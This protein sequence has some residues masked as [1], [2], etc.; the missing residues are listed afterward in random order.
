[1]LE[2]IWHFWVLVALSGLCGY[3]ALCVQSTRMLLQT[4][5]MY[6]AVQSAKMLLRMAKMYVVLMLRETAGIKLFGSGVIWRCAYNRPKC[7]QN[8]ENATGNQLVFRMRITYQ[9]RATHFSA[10][11]IMY[12]YRATR[13]SARGADHVERVT[14]YV[15][16]VFGCSYFRVVLGYVPCLTL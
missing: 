11:R 5:T 8:G 9:Y 7:Y 15:W 13:F 4:T 16:R 14:A 1:M 3:L 2:L 10:M 12:R 6:D